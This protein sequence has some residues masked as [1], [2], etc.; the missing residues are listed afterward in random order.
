MAAARL[1]TATDQSN[2]RVGAFWRFSTWDTGQTITWHNG[3]TG[4]YASYLG[5]DAAQRL[6]VIVLTDVATD[7]AI[8]NLGIALPV[9]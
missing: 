2:T 1:T 7:S 5:L 3:Q 6:A 9:D 4:G 8:T